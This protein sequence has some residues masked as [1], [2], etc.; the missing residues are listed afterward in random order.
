MASSTTAAAAAAD[1]DVNPRAHMLPQVT[2]TDEITGATY[3]RGGL[4]GRGAFSQ[5]YTVA[6]TQ[7]RIYAVKAVARTLLQKKKEYERVKR[8]IRIHKGLAHRFVVQCHACLQDPN[9]VYIL[10]EYCSNRSLMALHLRRRALTEPEGR[11]FFA[12]L[13]E[14]TRYLHR[15][16]VIHRDLKLGNLFLSDAMHVKVGDFGLATKVTYDGERQTERCGTPNYMAP[17][18]VSMRKGGYSFEVDIWALGC[19]LYTLLVGTPPFETHSIKTTFSKI[20]SNDYCIPASAG[21]SAEATRM[22]QVLLQSDPLQRPSPHAILQHPFL[23][24]CYV[25]ATLPPS[26]LHMVPDLT[27]IPAA[28]PFF[29]SPTAQAGMLATAAT[30][31][32]PV[33]ARSHSVCH[34]VRTDAGVS[35]WV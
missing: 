23:S 3:L 15:C 32:D 33:P 25:P 27:G 14:A 13:V 17:E 19:I 6:D 24:Q 31:S 20:R 18:M 4:I 22:I 11:Y 7:K 34:S 2:I 12:Q 30:T 28:A 1:M 35:S 5:C 10:L 26:A 9:F 29:G 16:K 8:E 21:L